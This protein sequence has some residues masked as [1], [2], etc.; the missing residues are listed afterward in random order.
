MLTKKE[1]EE[2]REWLD[3]SQN[4]VFFFDNDIDG[5]S[6]FLLLKRKIKKG[7][8][9][10]IKS[11]PGLEAM[12]IH[13]LE[14]IKPD[15][16]FVLDKPIISKEFIEYAIELGLPIIWIDH[17]PLQGHTV[18]ELRDMNVFYFNPLMSEKQSSEPV[19]YWCYKISGNEKDLWIAMMGCV[20]DHF[21]PEFAEKF[22]KEYPDISINTKDPKEYYKK[23][24]L[25]RIIKII[26]FAIKDKTSKVAKIME[27][28]AKSENPYEILNGD[29]YEDIIKRYH[30]IEKKFSKILEKAEKKVTDK[31]LLY[32]EYSGDL[33]VSAEISGELIYKYPNKIIVVIFTKG[34]KANMSLRGNNVRDL[35]NKAMKGIDG[36]G[37]GHKDACG[38]TMNTKDLEK[39]K[40]NI[41]DIIKENEI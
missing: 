31:K 9:V 4:P 15:V 6:S 21:V 39:F 5:L 13:K 19:S 7:Q 33:S 26:S 41:V 20:A 18:K 36:T 12:Y 34:D 14:E 23:S 24:E 28:L 8:G 35:L 27:K 30:E 38:G 10:I 3:K 16:I 25:G 17:H 1:I 29:G 22:S 11:Y 32:F 40:S 2:I 37:G